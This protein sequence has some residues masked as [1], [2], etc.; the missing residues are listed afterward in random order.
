MI[1]RLGHS[2]ILEREL[3]LLELADPDQL[4]ENLNLG[5]ARFAC[6]VAWDARGVGWERVSNF[7]NRLMDQ[8]LVYICAW[9]P[10][11][12][13]VH[14]IFEEEEVVRQ[15]DKEELEGVKLSTEQDKEHEG[16]YMSTWHDKEPLS[17]TIEFVLSFTQPDEAYA[18]GCDS[19]LA[20]V[21]GSAEWA[22]E[23]REAFKDPKGFSERVLEKP[24]E[25]DD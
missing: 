25:D 14:D 21:I 23:V 12:A 22:A 15:L 16:I 1:E 4:P 8:G 3:Y 20:I 10:D 17:E 2:S 18:A 9:G 7:V 19:T 24:D 13:R 6:L 5:S 11:C